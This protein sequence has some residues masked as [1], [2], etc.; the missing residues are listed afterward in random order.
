MSLLQSSKKI[1]TNTI[2]RTFSPGWYITLFQSIRKK[3]KVNIQPEEFLLLAPLSMGEGQ[4][5]FDGTGV[6]S[7]HT[8]AGK[9]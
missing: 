7:K 2:T 3:L 4:V 8:R 1:M 6:R 5:P 9:P